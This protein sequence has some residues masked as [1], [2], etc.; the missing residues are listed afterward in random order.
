MVDKIVKAVQH[1]QKKM[2]KQMM[3]QFWGVRGNLPVPGEDT[4]RYGGNTNCVT[5][6][7]PDKPL[8]IF[9]AG[10][11][12]RKLSESLGDTRAKPITG[13]I[14]ISHPHWDHINA[15]PYFGPLYVETNE[16]EFLAGCPENTTVKDLLLGQMDLV[17]FPVTIE[18]MNS[19]MHFRQLAEETFSFDGIQVQTMRLNHPGICLGYRV[20][21][22]NAVFCYVTDN[23]LPLKDSTDYSQVFVDKLRQFIQGAD[24]LVIDCTYTDEEYLQKIGW[25]H[26]CISTVVDLANKAKVKRLCLFHHHPLQKDKQIDEKL[27]SAVKRLKDQGSQTVCLAPKEGDKIIIEKDNG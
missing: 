1:K 4:L 20:Q 26:S 5:V 18:V 12:I 7:I 24:V 25:G 17:H 9:D 11:G 14:F 15:L 8:L 6:H 22:H 23:E 19:T 13:K 2:Q 27:N 3:I 10:S 16:F 21:Y